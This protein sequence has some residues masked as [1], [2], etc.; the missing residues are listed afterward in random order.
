[1]LQ[2]LLGGGPLVLHLKGLEIMNDD[3]SDVNVL[4]L[5]VNP[6]GGASG[7]AGGGSVLEELFQMVF[8]GYKEAGLLVEVGG[9]RDKVI[10]KCRIAFSLKA[11]REW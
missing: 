9:E 2:E 11:R 7:A 8:Q 4:Y 3:P 6:S 5:K 1:V 10:C